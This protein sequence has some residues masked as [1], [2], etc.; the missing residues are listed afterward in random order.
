M[1]FTDDQ[2]AELGD[3][4]AGPNTPL[5]MTLEHY[6]KWYRELSE[7]DQ[8]DAMRLCMQRSAR[9]LDELFRNGSC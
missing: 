9:I 4:I 5:L 3:A 7:E 1:T 6:P 2:I 8:A